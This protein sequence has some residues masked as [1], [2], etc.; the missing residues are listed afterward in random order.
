MMLWILKLR[1]LYLWPISG[2]S[3]ASSK[4]SRW[5]SSALTGRGHKYSP[6]SSF[7]GIKVNNLISGF[8]NRLL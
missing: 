5:L 8:P 6:T 7:K 1:N 2:E 4:D 3:R